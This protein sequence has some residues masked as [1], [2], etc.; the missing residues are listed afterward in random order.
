MG[1]SVSIPD[2]NSVGTVIELDKDSKMSLVEFNGFKFRIPINK[3]EKVKKGKKETERSVNDFIKFDA[4]SRIDVRGSRAEDTMKLIDDFIAE[5]LVANVTPLTIVHGKG[6]GALRQSIH[7]NLR[8]HPS[9]K[10]YRLGE[11]VEGGAGVTIVDI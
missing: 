3:L 8:Q 7:Q 10:S 6:T 5:A 9:V 2:S 1:D 4:S 11:L